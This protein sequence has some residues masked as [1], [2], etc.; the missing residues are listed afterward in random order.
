MRVPKETT[1]I[2]LRSDL[3]FSHQVKGVCQGV[4]HHLAALGRRPRRLLG[5]TLSP[6]D[7]RPGLEEAEAGREQEEVPP[8]GAREEGVEEGVAAGVDG[9]E[10]H[11][12][13]LG[14]RD[15]DE[16]QLEGG[17]HGEEG[18]G[19][20]AHEVGEDEDSHA[21]GHA[22]IGVG[23]HR[24]GVADAHVDAEVAAAHADEGQDVEDQEG[25]HVELRGWGVHVH[26][27]ADAHL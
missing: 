8:E 10:E 25:D 16:R 26:R 19:R 2:F 6:V 20:H 27:Q 13:Q 5:H 3:L 14:L 24:A 12:Q 1:G 17:R 21:L 22:G 4:D 11:Q 15:G 7:L 9:V 18:D 23:R